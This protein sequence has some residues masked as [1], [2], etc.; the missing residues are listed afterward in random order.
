VRLA[1]KASKGEED[2]N[3]LSELKEWVCIGY[4]LMNRPPMQILQRLLITGRKHE[5]KSIG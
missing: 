3:A 4:S 2:L 5:E 1:A